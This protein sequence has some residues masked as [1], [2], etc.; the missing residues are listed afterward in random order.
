MIGDFIL[1]TFSIL[2]YD[3]LKKYIV[4]KSVLVRKVLD[5]QQ[6]DIPRNVLSL[7]YIQALCWYEIS[8]YF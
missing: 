6:F 7:V 2:V 8:N 3:S 5:F 1:E 4:G